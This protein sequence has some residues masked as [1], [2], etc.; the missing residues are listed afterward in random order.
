MLSVWY[1]KQSLLT[2]L[3]FLFVTQMHQ[4]RTDNL[5][6]Y[7]DLP[8]FQRQPFLSAS[9]SDLSVFARKSYLLTR[10][11]LPTTRLLLQTVA[12]LFKSLWQSL[13]QHPVLGWVMALLTLRYFSSLKARQSWIVCQARWVWTS[14]QRKWLWVPG[15]WVGFFCIK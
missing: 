13:I 10:S 11:A 14:A 9:Q 5:L 1:L 12:L 4:P 6:K 2:L 3:D 15:S 8:S 7:F